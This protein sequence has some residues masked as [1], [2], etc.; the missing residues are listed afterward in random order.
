MVSEEEV[1]IKQALLLGRGY[2]EIPLSFLEN[3]YWQGILKFNSRHSLR[4]VFLEPESE[5]AKELMKERISEAKCSA[6]WT[7]I[8]SK[9][10]S[11][12]TSPNNVSNHWSGRVEMTLVINMEN[13]TEEKDQLSV[14][15]CDGDKIYAHTR[16]LPSSSCNPRM[17]SL[18]SKLVS[19]LPSLKRVPS[20]ESLWIAL[21][22]S[23][24]YLS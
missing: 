4:R 11:S 21:P 19:P 20:S 24:I 16:V 7:E 10:F 23:Q 15:F 22:P 18:H 1:K 2:T 6:W 13:L 5:P 17:F 3:A 14:Y 12:N 8:T 9:I